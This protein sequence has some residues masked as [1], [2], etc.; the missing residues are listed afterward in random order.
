MKALKFIGGYVTVVLTVAI[1]A[2]P[3][4]MAKANKQAEKD[5]NSEKEGKK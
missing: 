2:T 3:V 4:I 5:F 1:I